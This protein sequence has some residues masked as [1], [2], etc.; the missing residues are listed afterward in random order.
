MLEIFNNYWVIAIS[1][2][3]FIVIIK[4]IINLFRNPTTGSENKKE[5]KNLNLEPFKNGINTIAKYYVGLH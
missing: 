4:K 1:I 5:I 2:F 3:I